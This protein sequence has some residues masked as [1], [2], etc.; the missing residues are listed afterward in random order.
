MVEY[1]D[2]LVGRVTAQLDALNLSDKTLVF[3][4]GDNG[5][6]PALRS[7][8]NGRE[9]TGDKGRPTDAGTHVP[10]LAQWKGHI[11]A[12]T[13]NQDLID[14]TDVLP[15]L[16]EITG[17]KLPAGA[18]IDGRS[19]APQLRGQKG[20]PRDWIFCH[21]DPRWGN[22]KF[23]RHAQD[24]QYKLYDDG[25]LYDYRQDPLEQSPL[26]Q[27]SLTP[28]QDKSRQKLQKALDILK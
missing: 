5:T 4:T 1:A 9:M 2:K 26:A 28:A 6:Y 12:G 15:T 22:F 7:V 20:K 8:I 23:S 17:S 18:T 19:F 21:Y 11:P 3:F 16:A 10:F 14:F 25:V 24:K 13:V 27:T